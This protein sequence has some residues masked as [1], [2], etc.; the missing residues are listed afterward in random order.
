VYV[1]MLLAGLL[2]AL[3][4]GCGG[5]PV[6]TGA[7]GATSASTTASGAPHEVRVL[8]LGDS[9]AVGEGIEPD[10]AWPAQLAAA[11]RPMGFEAE[12]TTIGDTGW[13]SRRVADALDR[14]A[15]AVSSLVVVAVGVNDHFYGFGSQRLRSNVDRILERSAPLVADPG[16]V[17]VLSIVDWRATLRGAEYAGTWRDRALE[18]YN[19]V[20]EEI[21]DAGGHRF[22][23]VTTPSMAMSA[24]ESLVAADGLHGSARLYARW[25]EQILPFALETLGA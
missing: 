10:G 19:A 23:D 25:T 8:V 20:L 15:A 22:V 16:D 24:D 14:G 4:A 11:L 17:I 3:V 12:I 5:A 6:A 1:K 2:V 18:P 7:T 21:A 9:F 13:T